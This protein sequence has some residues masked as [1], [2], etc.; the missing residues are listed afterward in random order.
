M[1]RVAALLTVLAAYAAAPA[2]AARL[3]FRRRS[4]PRCT[5]LAA[6]RRRGDRRGHRLALAVGA[7]HAV[8]RRR[9]RARGS[10]RPHPPGQGP[11]RRWASGRR[12]AAG[13]G[14]RLRRADRHATAVC[15]DPAPHVPV[16]RDLVPWR[17]V[18]DRAWAVA[19]ALRASA[20]S[21]GARLG[22]RVDRDAAHR[23]VDRGLHRG[24][25][26]PPHAAT[27]H[28]ARGGREPRPDARAHARPA[29]GEHPRSA[30]A[31]DRADG[32]GAPIVAFVAALLAAGS[33]TGCGSGDDQLAAAGAA[34]TTATTSTVPARG[35]GGVLVAVPQVVTVSLRC[36]GFGK[37]V[38]TVLA[39]RPPSVSVDSDR[40]CR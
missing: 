15:P 22:G 5:R 37:S 35:L 25:R 2:E 27:A 10:H 24:R 16:A 4:A 11:A 36:V 29:V 21:A 9:R 1:R 39:V 32:A 19:P 20:D 40:E 38:E 12:P 34:S 17:G 8:P 18:V 7:R 14:R 23:C 30:T 3:H 28:V 33:A 26:R 13:S 31:A 6:D